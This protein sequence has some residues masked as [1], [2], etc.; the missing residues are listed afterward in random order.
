M[1]NFWNRLLTGLI[2]SATRVALIER[3][4]QKPARW[5]RWLSWRCSWPLILRGG[6]VHTAAGNAGKA[7]LICIDPAGNPVAAACVNGAAAEQ[8]RHRLGGT[9]IIAQWREHGID[10]T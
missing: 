4:V 7:T 8:R 9:A 3:R 10:R 2:I 6:D 1:R 5:A